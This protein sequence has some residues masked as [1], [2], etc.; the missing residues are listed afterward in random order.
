MFQ[1]FEQQALP[2][3]SREIAEILTN[4]CQIPSFTNSVGEKRVAPFFNKTLEGVPYF[5]TH[6]EHLG[7]WKMERDPLERSVSWAIIKG[8]TSKC[9]VL[10]HHSDVVSSE[11][12]GPYQDIALD[13]D[14]IEKAFEND[15]TLLDEMARQDLESGEWVFGRGTA[16]MK[17][18]GAIQLALFKHYGGMDKDAL[19]QLPTLILLALPDEET[20]SA[21]MRS[22]LSL[23]RH[24]K[25]QHH[26]DYILMI[27]SEPHQRSTP[28]NGM[29]YQGSIAKYNL[30][31]Y[32]RGVMAHV[33]KVLEGVNPNGILSRIVSKSDLSMDFVDHV[34]SEVSIP[35]TWIF[36]RDLKKQYD[37]SFPS[38]CYGM[39][40]LL[41][42]NTDPETVVTK[43][44]TICREALTGYLNEID[45]IREKL[46]KL[47]GR[48]QT[49]G[50]ARGYTPRVLTYGEL[51]RLSLETLPQN[52]TEDPQNLEETLAA[53]SAGIH[54]LDPLVVVGFCPPYYPGVTNPDPN[55]LLTPIR[56]F[57]MTQWGQDYDNSAYFSGI[58]DLSYAMAAGYATPVTENMIGWG[59]HYAIPFDE[60]EEIS[61]ACLNIG[62]W[63]KDY[64]RPSERVF[65]ED[66]FNRTPQL[67]DFVIREHF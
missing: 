64:H 25:V 41:N 11:N 32:V 23:L 31:V 8:G 48:S 5:K 59:R 50:S 35:P 26:L 4:Y 65:K 2:D 47:S 13:P 58:S 56:A 66:L 14:A 53:L 61:M 18:G 57:S 62:P 39:F 44:V 55:L 24:L 46:T 40:N 15:S 37:V 10:I 3:L 36:M 1:P 12:Y 42:F 34:G 60:I 7:T 63:G 45:G 22:A 6:P 30:F 19:Q 17:G 9:V 21:G 27:N 43:M 29:I 54:P 51:K 20:L 33:G 16:D 52:V 67:I 38:A 28:E 49:E